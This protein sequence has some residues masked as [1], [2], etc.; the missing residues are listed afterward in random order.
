MKYYHSTRNSSI[1]V[2]GAQAVLQG[3]APDGG[4]F[5]PE[6]FEKLDLK[7]LF[8]LDAYGLFARVLCALLG[9][10]TEQEMRETVVKGYQGRFETEEVTPLV[11]VG[12]THILELFRGPTS[13]FKDV[14]LSLLPYFITRAA[15]EEQV[16]DEI[17]ILTATSGDTGKAALAGFAD[18]PGTS[19]AVFYPHG[20]VSEIQ[21][22]QMVTQRG[23]N[24]RVCAVRGN[25]DDAQTG[26]KAI[27]A[28]EGLKARLKEKSVRLSSAN[29]IN[30]GRLAPQVAYYF[31]AYGDLMRRGVIRMGDAVN[32]AVPTGNFGDILA[33][34]Y[35]RHMG[36]PVGK[37]LC[38]SNRNRVL[39]DYLATGVYD[40]RREFFHTAS[41]SMDILVSSN[42]ERCLHLLS[43]GDCALVADQM[44][45]LQRQGYYRT[46][47]SVMKA[48]R[49]DFFGGYA[50]DEDC[51]R[52]IDGLYRET[53]Y[54]M[55]PHTAV[56][57]AV[58]RAYREST[59]DNRP[60]VV[61]ATASPYKFAPDVLR[62]LRQ[63][64]AQGFA[65]LRR[66]QEK[67]GVP[68]PKNLSE[69][70][71]L[72]ELHR[73]VIDVSQMPEYVEK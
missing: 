40:R 43:G 30:L 38:A 25:F 51:F 48:F 29:S 16:T 61:L 35:A 56:A 41:P 21:R 62:A 33:G 17:R 15:R 53:N 69:L 39:A 8:S 68:I 19:I 50:S 36:L 4:L 27:F 32:F 5:V 58:S 24:V 22:R 13:A 49:R 52:A 12:D 23:Q 72:P 65:A 70:E 7:E 71:G 46:P 44:G 47:E 64:D 73:D 9:G 45:Q 59:G 66:L 1:S 63:E 18:V 11:T 10:W 26:V 37:L 34:E 42:L 3:I 6:N 28:N 55:D 31:K 20:G 60:M 54:L 2:N 67:T 57:Y 14:A